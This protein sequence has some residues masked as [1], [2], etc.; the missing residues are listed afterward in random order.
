MAHRPA[1]SRLSLGGGLKILAA[2]VGIIIPSVVATSLYQQHW[3]ELLAAEVN[4]A[5]TAR[6]LEQHAARTV[7]TVDTFL[8]AVVSLAGSRAQ[9]LSPEII[10]AALSEKLA[11]S[12]DLTNILILNADGGALHE[13][14]GFPARSR[15]NT[16]VP[17]HWCKVWTMAAPSKAWRRGAR[18]A[19]PSYP[20]TTFQCR[21]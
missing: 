4:T 6:A 20:T 12:N 5:N 15:S 19:K 1:R 21:R 11:Q 14:I 13:A 8:K 10:H 9:S 16:H 18:Q 7:E 2:V 3:Q 17:L